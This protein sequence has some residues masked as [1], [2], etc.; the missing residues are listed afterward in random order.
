M[1][2]LA[3][4]SVGFRVNGCGF[5]DT[6]QLLRTEYF[7]RNGSARPRNLILSQMPEKQFRMLARYLVPVDLPLG[8]RLSVSNELVEN[9]YFPTSGLVSVDGLT[10]RGESVEVAVIGREAYRGSTDCWVIGR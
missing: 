8:V 5:V 2:S 6:E 1:Y 7:S 4:V 9:I 10:E 3:H